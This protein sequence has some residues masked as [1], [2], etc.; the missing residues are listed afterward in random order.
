MNSHQPYPCVRP[1]RLWTLLIVCL[2]SPVLGQAERAPASLAS[3]NDLRLAELPKTESARNAWRDRT[4]SPL[5]NSQ[6][7]ESK[8]KLQETLKKLKSIRFADHGELETSTTTQE[9]NQ[10]S[11]N[12][13]PR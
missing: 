1:W 5:Q 9:P 3:A 6:D 12:T 10:S 2:C 4:S 8:K 13:Q 7:A 11:T